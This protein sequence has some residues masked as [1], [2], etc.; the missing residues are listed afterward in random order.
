V[1]TETAFHEPTARLLERHAELTGCSTHAYRFAWRSSALEGR[2]GAAHAVDLPFVFDALGAPG[3][4]GAGDTLLGSAGGSPEL[5]ASMHAAW[6]GFVAGDGPGWPAY[7]Q[8][9]RF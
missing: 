4:S 6:V 1:I 3:I 5:A 9:E 8:V 2:L 7:P